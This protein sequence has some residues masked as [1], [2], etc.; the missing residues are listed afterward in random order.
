MKELA[1]SNTKQIQIN[2]KSAGQKAS[3]QPSVSVPLPKQ[4]ITTHYQKSTYSAIKRQSPA[5][6]RKQPLPTSQS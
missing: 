4:K 6:A 5:S 3:V 1:E 2:K